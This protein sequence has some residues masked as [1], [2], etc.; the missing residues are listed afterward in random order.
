M[1][2]RGQRSKGEQRRP[3]SPALGQLRWIIVDALTIAK[4]NLINS[5]R[6]PQQLIFSTIQPVMLLLLF[7]YVFGGAIERAGVNYRNFL[8]PGILVQIVAF[9]AMSTGIGHATDINKG[10]LDRFRSLP[11]AR[12][13]VLAGRTVADLIRNLFSL[14]LLFA[15]GSLVGF[16]IQSGPLEALAA[17]G[18]LLMFGYALSWIGAAVAMMLRDPEAVQ[19]AGFVWL[20]PLVFASGI[21]VPVETMPG[22]L[23]PFA[24][25][26]PLGSTAEA[27]RGLLLDSSVGSKVLQATAWSAVLLAVT[28]PLSVYK[29]RRT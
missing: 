7:T 6:V 10:L 3:D 18:I 20:F 25:H 27:V 11:M 8:L 16:R 15:V 23:Q 29:Y 28:I 2:E 17:L 12:S 9:S 13:A 21:F 24:R 14:L 26:Q 22:W 5:T 1:A 4:R 19:A